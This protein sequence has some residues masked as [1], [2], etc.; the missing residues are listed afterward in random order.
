MI[1]N[2]RSYVISIRNKAICIITAR[3]SSVQSLKVPTNIRQVSSQTCT[4][5]RA[6]ICAAWRPWSSSPSLPQSFRAT[7]SLWNAKSTL[8]RFPSQNAYK[9]SFCIKKDRDIE[10][11]DK[12]RIFVQNCHQIQF[13]FNAF[14]LNERIC[15]SWWSRMKSLNLNKYGCYTLKL[16]SWF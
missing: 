6:S 8:F 10:P 15:Q 16:P 11:K 9:D 1:I 2:S 7:S 12:F 4:R 14:I 13:N 3:Q 5:W